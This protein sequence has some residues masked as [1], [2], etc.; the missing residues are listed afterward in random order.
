MEASDRS[1]TTLPPALGQSPEAESPSN[2]RTAP[3]QP[4]TTEGSH[5]WMPAIGDRLW[6]VM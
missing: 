6:I 4:D 3:W 2:D 1:F 5:E